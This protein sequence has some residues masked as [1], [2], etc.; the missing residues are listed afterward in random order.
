MRAHQH[1]TH[2]MLCATP[3]AHRVQEMVEEPVAQDL[4]GGAA[5]R[6][7]ILIFQSSARC[8]NA[9]IVGRVC[10]SCLALRLEQGVAASARV[11]QR[12]DGL[13]THPRAAAGL[14]A[15]LLVGVG[16]ACRRHAS[17]LLFVF[18]VLLG[19]IVDAGSAERAVQAAGT[20][21]G[22]AANLQRGSA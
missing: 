1:M 2:A 9:L 12:S 13:R 11:R 20:G 18:T 19:I 5:Q 6:R 15:A 14:G 7:V 17:A 4:C 21:I 16:G 22:A 8:R 10:R 3:W